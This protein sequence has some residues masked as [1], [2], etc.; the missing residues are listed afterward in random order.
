MGRRPLVLVTNDDGVHAV[1][2]IAAASAVVD[3]ADV[4][5]V[6][7]AT[8][9]T[10]MARA[11]ARSTKAG[12]ITQHDLLIGGREIPTF[13]VHGSP[14]ETVAHAI[15]EITPRLPDLCI[16]GVNHGAN[17]GLAVGISGTVGA[18]YEA[19]SLGVPSIAVS[20]EMDVDRAC[21]VASEWSVAEAVLARFAARCLDGL[22]P[23]TAVLNLNFPSGLDAQ[24]PIRRTRQAQQDVFFPVAPAPRDRAMPHR[25][26]IRGEIDELAL[27]SD[28]DVRVVF[29][30]RHVSYTLLRRAMDD[31]CGWN[32]DLHSTAH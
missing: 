18:A 28:D 30:D 7:P 31:D 20:H 24:T 15:L 5:V 2:L 19:D 26:A 10:G 32:V 14:A 27:R 13:S 25:L 29:L 1:G 6:A 16:A 12:S 8:D 3:I 17:V 11:Y 9:Q 22:P 4:V 23:S 21:Y